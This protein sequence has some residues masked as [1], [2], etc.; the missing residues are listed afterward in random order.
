MSQLDSTQEPTQPSADSAV[1]GLVHTVNDSADTNRQGPSKGTVLSARIAYLLLGVLLA[2]WAALVPYAKHRLGVDEGAFGI[3]LFFVGLGGFLAIPIAG[4]MTARFGC[5]AVLCF[6][7]PTMFMTTIALATVS[8]TILM[9]ISLMAY[10][11]LMGVTEVGVKVQCALVERAI[12]RQMMSSFH[13]MY[14]LGGIVGAILMAALLSLGASPFWSSTMM[15]IA[16]ICLVFGY[17]RPYFLPYADVE[18]KNT[19]NAHDKHK[20]KLFTLPKGIV[21]ALGIVCF[22][23]YTCEGVM[24]DWA[25]LFLNTERGVPTSQSGIAYAIFASTMTLGR[26][27]GDRITLRFGSERVMAVSACIAASG[28]LIMVFAGTNWLAFLGITLIGGGYANLTPLLFS[29]ASRKTTIGMSETVAGVATLGYLGLLIGPA[30]MGFVGNYLG[31]GAIFVLESVLML[32]VAVSIV[33]LH[34]A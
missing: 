5:R 3:L 16:A 25:A 31:L 22:L 15:T 9:T 30:M 24:L 14:S 7:L 13:A 29:L 1:Q 2:V 26:L 18:E 32:T 4:T 34:R 20:R 10:G 6:A 11:A 28:L 21:F 19:G 23:L 33:R 27:L 12:G 17:C 8:N